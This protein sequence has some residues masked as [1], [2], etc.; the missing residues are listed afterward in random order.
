M[1]VIVD[2]EYDGSALMCD[3]QHRLVC[4]GPEALK[5]MT[6]SE[7]CGCDG[8]IPT[9]LTSP[10]RRALW[11]VAGLNLAMGLVEMTAGYF[12]RSQALK[13]DALDFLGDGI[14]TG[15]GLIA[16]N[17]K[18]DNRARAALVQGGFLA[19][20]GLGVLATTIH[21]VFVAQM[22]EAYVV[23]S[24]GLVALAVNMACATVL[25]RFRDGDANVRAVWLFSRNDAIGNLVVVLAAA[26]IAAFGSAW[27]DLI[28]ALA[29]A[30][31]FVHSAVG[32]LRDALEE[33]KPRS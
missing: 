9:H 17:W 10:Y 16:L 22:P 26:A 29:I 24:V 1:R 27:P 11:F 28:A 30:A 6:K 13:A 20:M 32:I 4:R 33:L 25:L 31:L 7:A 14:I 2:D 23:G 5:R 8:K 21:R 19:L 12:G 3:T 18:A 15:A